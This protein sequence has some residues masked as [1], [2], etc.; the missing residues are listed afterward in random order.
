VIDLPG[1]PLE[2]G[3]NATI[4]AHRTFDGSPGDGDQL[5]IGITATIFVNDFTATGN[6]QGRLIAHHT[7]LAPTVDVVVSRDYS[8]PSSP[9]MTVPFANPTSTD[10]EAMMSQI[11]AEFRPGEWQV[12][13]EF[14]GAAVFGPDTIKLRPYTATYVYAVGDFFRDNFSYLVF[15]ES[16]L[17]PQKDS[18][19]VR[20][21]VNRRRR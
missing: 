6:G 21:T 4:V 19:E 15:T 7:A 3:A 20:D 18:R 5:G 12:T 13:L 9:G 17:K 11:N 8:D 2:A 14:D 16:D 1:V 10:E